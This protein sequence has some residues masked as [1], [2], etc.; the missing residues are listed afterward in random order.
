MV[1]GEIK[2]AKVVYLFAGPDLERGKPAAKLVVID[3]IYG[4]GDVLAGRWRQRRRC[5][6]VA[7]ETSWLLGEG[8]TFYPLMADEAG[9]GEASLASG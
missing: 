1:T 3:S 5:W 4:C 2:D 6:C 8:G 9:V 7:V